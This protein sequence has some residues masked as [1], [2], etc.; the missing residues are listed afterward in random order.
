MFVLTILEKNKRT[1]VEIFT[2][3]RS[4]FIKDDKL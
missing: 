3:K 4:G 1:D 2:R